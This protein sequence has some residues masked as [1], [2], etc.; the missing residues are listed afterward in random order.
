M[1]ELLFEDEVNRQNQKN[2]SD[3]M[4]QFEGFGFE[5][6]QGENHEDY[7]CDHLLDN[8]QFDQ[9][10]WSSVSGKTDFVGWNLKHIFEEC[11]APA[12]QDD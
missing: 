9:G 4:I 5:S 3:Q 8:F 7:Q 2:C 11:D 1:E 12:D 10:K 6:N